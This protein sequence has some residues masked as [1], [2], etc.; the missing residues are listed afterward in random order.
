M[1]VMETTRQERKERYYVAAAAL[2]EAKHG[3]LVRDHEEH[4]AATARFREAAEAANDAFVDYW[5]NRNRPDPLSAIRWDWEGEI[6]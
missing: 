2:E 5:T 3:L 6:V 1:R 4:K